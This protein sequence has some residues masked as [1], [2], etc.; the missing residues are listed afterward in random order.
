MEPTDVATLAGAVAVL[1]TALVGVGTFLAGRAKGKAE[2]R[3]TKFKADSAE[4]ESLKAQQEASLEAIS[5]SITERLDALAEEVT[6]IKAEVKPNHGGSLKDAIVRIEQKQDLQHEITDSQGHQIGEIR[7]E[8]D[9]ERKDRQQ[10]AEEH[11]RLWHAINLI[12]HD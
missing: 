9:G 3:L 2:T 8:L 12:I 5:G 10:A 11:G 4:A 7:K 6:S 1:L